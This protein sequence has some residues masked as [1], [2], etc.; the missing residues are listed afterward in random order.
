[1][2][3]NIFESIQLSKSLQVS[4]ERRTGGTAP[5]GDSAAPVLCGVMR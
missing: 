2:Q 4:S 3:L 5:A 1:M